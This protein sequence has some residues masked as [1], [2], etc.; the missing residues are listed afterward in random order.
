LELLT[1]LRSC[2]LALA[3]LLPSLA[4]AAISGVVPTSTATCCNNLSAV[5][6]A[7]VN[8]WF[9]QG[10]TPTQ[11]Y[12]QA[13]SDYLVSSG[14]QAAWGGVVSV[15]VDEGWA[16]QS[17]NT[18]VRSGGNPVANSTNFPNL[19]AL[20]A[21]IKGNGQIAGMYRDGGQI[22]CDSEDWGAGTLSNDLGYFFQTL[23]FQLV[24]LD[25]CGVNG[26]SPG[27]RSVYA[28]A[29]AALQGFGIP[30]IYTYGY[31]HSFSGYNQ[32]WAYMPRTG[33]AAR[34][35]F[36]SGTPTPSP[37]TMGFDS[38]VSFMNNIWAAAHHP[39][40]VGP[41]H[42]QDVDFLG[43]NNNGTAGSLTT[44]EAIT[45][46]AMVA[47]SS[48]PWILGCDP[49]ALGTGELAALKNADL[50]AVL[51][52][53]WVVGGRRYA[54]VHPNGY[55]TNP[56]NE[57]FYKR[58]SASGSRAIV[59]VNENA[60]GQGAQTFT[61]DPAQVGIDT[62]QTYTFKNILT[63]STTTGHTGTFNSASVPEH[64]SAVYLII[65]GTESNSTCW[66]T[67]PGGTGQITSGY[68]GGCAF[69]TDNNG[70]P[71]GGFASDGTTVSTATAISTAGLTDPAPQGCYQ[72]QRIGVI[73]SDDPDEAGIEYL[74][75][76][77]VAGATYHYRLHL[78]EIEGNTAGARLFN[79]TLNTGIQS[80]ALLTSYDIFTSAGGANKAIIVEGNI[81]ADHGYISFD[82]EPIA[83]TPTGVP[84]TG[85]IEVIKQ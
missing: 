80:V 69:T 24:K 45:Q 27:G 15:S 68:P 2:L 31:P 75:D 36:D 26:A 20:I 64:A 14:L 82:F 85:C 17:G 60:S 30:Y 62:T 47:I 38:G 49:T 29:Y 3:L 48:S 50:I 32:T 37:C 78:A 8:T 41:Y 77:L 84:T 74:A 67:N 19:P 28:A 5:P 9:G 10:P 22:G 83:A 34:I 56:T 51:K 53:S 63:G 7:G 61:I 21:H 12:L 16:A 43:A 59:V 73:S 76:N 35:S 23:G 65:A 81:T 6:W 46:M 58:L 4:W 44:D 55:G 1:V 57:S 54:A 71:A 42:L 18:V 11:A 25:G 79:L 66:A 72:K 33:T 52:D 40:V 13:A 70:S 39:G